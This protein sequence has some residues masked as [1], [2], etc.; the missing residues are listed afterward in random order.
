MISTKNLIKIII[1]NSPKIV[2]TQLI[3]NNAFATHFVYSVD[4]NILTD[5][6]IDGEK[7]KIEK[8]HFLSNYENANWI[9]NQ[10]V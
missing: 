5:E 8:S 2:E 6:G 7:Y 10:I 1:E 9:L 4:G 3:L